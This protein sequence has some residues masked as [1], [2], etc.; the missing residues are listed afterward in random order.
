MLYYAFCNLQQGCWHVG[1]RACWTCGFIDVG[2]KWR[3]VRC[4]KTFASIP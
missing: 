3:L 1:R 2:N 4:L